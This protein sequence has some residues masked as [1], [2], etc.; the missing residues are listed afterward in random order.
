MKTNPAFDAKKTWQ[1]H[2]AF[3]LIE[4]LVVIAIIGILAGMLLPALGRAKETAKRVACVNN[5]RQL[6][7]AT[8][9]YAD[10]HEN[11]FP[12]RQV[13]AEPGAW[14]TTL[15][16]GYKDLRVLLCP[17][18]SPNAATVSA[19]QSPIASHFP[20][21]S[22]RSYMM[23]GW[24]D[25]WEQQ[26]ARTGQPFDIGRTVGQLMPE[27]A[28]EMPSETILLGE[29][30]TESPHFYMDFLESSPSSLDGNLF[31][32]VEH[33]RHSR[34][35]GDSSTGGSNYVFAD[36][37]TRYLRH[38]AALSPVNLWGVT[39]RWRQDVSR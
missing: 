10:D 39:A 13:G 1:A 25:Y 16:D 35:S 5:L 27:S 22:P 12:P 38:W 28:V 20:D 26:W 36:G 33:G 17:T 14:A 29:K 6:G 15:Y 34:S 19:A 31:D 32:E 30:L 4:L 23:N 7:I 18:D 9:L 37:S 8:I 3:T 2:G 11:K 24:N 21:R